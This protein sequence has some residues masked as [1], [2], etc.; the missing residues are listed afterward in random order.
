MKI[1]CLD[2]FFWTCKTD[3]NGD[4]SFRG[5]GG[6]GYVFHGIV[7][8][9]VQGLL[10]KIHGH[11]FWFLAQ[12][13]ATMLGFYTCTNYLHVCTHNLLFWYVESNSEKPCTC[14]CISIYMI[15]LLL[16]T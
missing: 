3:E 10:F 9:T 12:L 14:T 4:R 8:V 15:K 13:S 6:G 16:R 1:K 5:G 7:P 2:F 11:V